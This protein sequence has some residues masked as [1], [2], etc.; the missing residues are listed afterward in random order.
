MGRYAS[1]ENAA[2]PVYFWGLPGE[3]VSLHG[4]RKLA[5]KPFGASWEKSPAD[6]N[7][8]LP[9]TSETRVKGPVKGTV[10]VALPKDG[11][12]YGFYL[13]VKSRAGLGEQPPRPGDLPQVRIES[14]TT[15]PNAELYAP[16]ADPGRRDRLLL[17]WRAEDRNLMTNPISLEWSAEPNG[18]WTFIG[19]P[20]LA[21]SGQYS[22]Q[23][24]DNIPAKVFL[25]LS[26]RDRAGNNAVA[27]TPNPVLIDLVTPG[28]IKAIEVVP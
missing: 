2:S 20:Q 8:S 27:Q 14:D 21:N 28:P 7:V 10:T 3:S 26:V 6:P 16:Q 23:V 1:N 17:H 25:R 22:W 13:V 5:E 15:L 19:D 9:V 12:A 11:V 24:P 18:P 4:L